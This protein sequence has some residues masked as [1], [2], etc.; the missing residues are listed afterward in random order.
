MNQR[1]YR[2]RFAP[3]P[4]Q[5]SLLRRTLGCV[6]LVYNKALFAR[7]EA[8]EERGESINYGQT[9]ALLTRWKQQDD[10]E[11]L[12]EV[13]CVPLQQ[14]LRHLQTAFNNFFKKRAGFPRF[15]KKRSGGSAEF[16]RSAF[17]WKDGQI[18]LAK[19]TQP[20]QIIWSRLLPN[21]CTPTTITVRLDA[22]GRWFV[23]LLVDDHTIKPLPQVDRSVGLDAGITSL[24]TTSDGEKIAN[25]KHFDRLRRKLRQVQKTLARRPDKSNN[26]EKARREVARVQARIADARSNFLHQLTTQLVRENQVISVEDLAVANMVKNRKLSRHVAD[27]AWGELVRQ[28]E[29]KCQWGGR[30][31]VKIDRW[32]PS[33]KRCGS[34]GHIV[35]KMPLNIRSWDC[36]KCGI[37]HD[38][39]L[40]AARN[41]LAAGLAVLAGNGE[42][43]CGASIRP[44]EHKFKGQLRKTGNGKKQKP[45]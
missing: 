3:T 14:T 44:D 23:S 24:V 31:L 16:T 43:V 40:N 28:L 20:L 21:G 30:T 26:R 13:S 11:F 7:K 15:K 36:P 41:I 2:Y 37:V 38:R 25:P 8:W 35:D 1:A 45:K 27:A 18:W 39:D 10:L 4:E 6:R 12:N 9:S 34:C 33:S 22:A 32:F 5:E 42:E 29:Y 19:F 17:K